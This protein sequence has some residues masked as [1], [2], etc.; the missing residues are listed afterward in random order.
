MAQSDQF[1]QPKTN[2]PSPARVV[3][4]ARWMFILIG[5]VWVVFGMMAMMNFAGTAGR[6]M[7]VLMFVNAAALL[8]VGIGLGWQNRLFFWL[9][10]AL[11]GG[12]ILLSVTD[13]I[14]FYDVV[15]LLYDIALLILLIVTRSHYLK[16]R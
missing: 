8:G 9:G 15:T 11:L 3:A 6:V 10:L 14:G 12:N 16:P 4:L 13:Q 7:G 1:T 2:Q 5:G